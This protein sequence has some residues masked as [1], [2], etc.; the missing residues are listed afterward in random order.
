M[1]TKNNLCNGKG[2][3][4]VCDDGKRDDGMTRTMPPALTSSQCTTTVIDGISTTTTGHALGG[5][6]SIVKPTR[7]QKEIIYGQGRR[8]FILDEKQAGVE[9][10]HRFG[11][12]WTT[13][14]SDDHTVLLLRTIVSIKDKGI[15][16][17]YYIYL[18][19][20]NF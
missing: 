7:A 20:R 12:N 18:F 16:V 15:N 6:P 3:D 9:G 4:D 11:R 19:K 5:L 13:I 2:N 17:T 8:R 1:V 10:S 14:L